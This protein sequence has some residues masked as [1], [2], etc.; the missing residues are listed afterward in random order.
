MEQQ[1]N[2]SQGTPQNQN[3]LYI[4]LGWIFFGISLLLIPLLFGAGA[5]V[6]GYLTRKQP[7]RETHGVILMVF[8]VA[9]AILGV[10]IGIATSGY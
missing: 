1:Q 2:Q 7:G 4:I 8:A 9:G 10:F 6:M 3:N 5:F